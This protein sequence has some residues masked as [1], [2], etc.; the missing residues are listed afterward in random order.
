MNPK[1]HTKIDHVNLS[2]FIKMLKVKDKERILKTARKNK[3]ISYRG[4]PIRLSANFSKATLQARKDWQETFKVMKSR[5]L[6]QDCSTQQKYHL[7]LKGS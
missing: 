7:E 1:V 5:D 2:P 4:F 6:H 3:L